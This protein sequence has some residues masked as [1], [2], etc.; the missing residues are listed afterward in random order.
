MELALLAVSNAL[1]EN[2]SSSA[3]N[4]R[5]IPNHRGL[6]VFTK[7]HDASNAHHIRLL[8]SHADVFTSIKKL[9]C[10]QFEFSVVSNKAFVE[11]FIDLI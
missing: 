10:F 3:A 8:S 7:P 2:K 11:V 1:D 4:L 9:A 6:A 5:S